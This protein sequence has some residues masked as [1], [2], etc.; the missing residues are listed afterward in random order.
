LA[1]PYDDQPEARDLTRPPLPGEAV[2]ATFC[3]T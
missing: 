2:E 3:G 1:R